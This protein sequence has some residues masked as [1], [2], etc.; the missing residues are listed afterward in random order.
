MTDDREVERMLREVLAARAD[1][2][3]D[4]TDLAERI[5]HEAALRPVE[6]LPRPHRWRTWTLPLVAA[7][8]VAAVVLGALVIVHLQ[9]TPVQSGPEASGRPHTVP[10]GAT[11]PG[12]PSASVTDS[13]VIDG[14]PNLTNFVAV[15]MTFIGPD[16]GWV[17]GSADCLNGSPG[18]CTAMART[19]HSSLWTQV[20]NPPV[21][22]P[23]VKNCAEPC[24]TDVR[25]ADTK[26]GYAFGPNALVMTTDGGVTWATEPGGAYALETLDGNVIRVVADHSGCPGPCNVSV[27]LSALGS[28]KWTTVRLPGGTVDGSSVSLSRTGSAAVLAVFHGTAADPQPATLYASTDDGHH[29]AK[30]DDPCPFLNRGVGQEL[31]TAADGS[32]SMLCVDQSQQAVATFSVDGAH[33]APGPLFTLDGGSAGSL[34]AASATTFIVSAGRGFYRTTDRGEHWTLVLRDTTSGGLAQ[35][36]FQSAADVHCVSNDGRKLYASDDAG[37]HW[38]ATPVS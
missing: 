13:A 19:K 30:Q 8:A 15:G 24:A 3:P 17:L 18:P 5:L 32:A 14:I 23:G 22:V 36:G 35:C 9:P 31:T 38:T 34:A 21:N 1:R 28:K 33:Y 2:A 37:A 6:T 27:Q 11:P 10:S 16:S 12:G 29:W 25:F 20:R 4:G 7:G 26:V